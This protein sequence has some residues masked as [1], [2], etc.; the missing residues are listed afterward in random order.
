[1]QERNLPVIPKVGSPITADAV[2]EIERIVA[3]R[4]AKTDDIDTLKEWRAQA[5]ALESYLRS[6]GLQRPMLGAQRRVE[7]RIGQLLG[8]APGRGKKELSPHADLFHRERREEFRLLARAFG[9]AK[10]KDWKDENWQ[11]SRRALVSLIRQMLGLLPETPPLPDGIFRCIVADPPWKLTTG[12]NAFGGTIEAGNEALPYEQM[13]LE[14]IQALSVQDHAADDAHLYLWTPDRY[15]E[16]SYGIARA[17]GFKPSALL[18]WAKK[19]HGIGLGGAYRLTTE[20][21]LYARRGSLEERRII[22]TTW[23]NW[24]RGKHSQKPAAFYEM[25]ESVSQGPFLEMFAR[26]ER[27]GW[28]VWGDEVGEAA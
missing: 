2:A 15:V 12:P 13:S 28:K 27:K 1:M 17:W 24:S 3:Q 7:A 8:P 4:I 22:E 21:I 19:P 14:D 6:R 23:F 9:C 20:F 18:V 5:A 25:V 11:K 10:Y 16:K 26:A